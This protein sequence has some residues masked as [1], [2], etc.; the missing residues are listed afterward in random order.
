MAT[1]G[2]RILKKKKKP[3]ASADD[4]RAANGLAR[5]FGIAILVLL[6][7]TAV[8]MYGVY[9]S[10]AGIGSGTRVELD[11]QPK[12][13]SDL[14]ETLKDAGL[15][16]NAPVF[17]WYVRLTGGTSS[18]VRGHHILTNDVTPRELLHRLER[19]N[20]SHTKI[21]VPEGWNRFDIAKRLDGAHV[22]T[23]RTFLEATTDEK[24][25]AELHI[26][27]PSAE[28]YLFPATYDLELDSDPRDIVKQMVH[29]FDKRY[30]AIDEKHE[31]GL[32]DLSDSLGWGRREIGD[33]RVARRKGSRGGRRARG[34]RERL[35]E[36]A[37]G[38]VV[39]A[40]APAKRSII[41]LRVPRDDDERVHVV[42]GKSHARGQRRSRQPVQHV[43]A[44]RL[45]A[46]AHRQPRREITRSRDEPC[47]HA[48]FLLRREGRRSPR[49]LGDAR[50]PQRRRARRRGTLSFSPRRR[51][52]G[53]AASRRAGPANRT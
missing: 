21:V 7:A 30:A 52:P 34:R 16:D 43:H 27:G 24:L 47:A 19:R 32:K 39:H 14:A 2:K 40:E 6:A 8:V 51:S 1:R 36:P 23:T 53:S 50:Q 5:W 48:L 45:A 25:L 18:I 15:I 13:A 29:Q 17:A 46:R 33:P 26:Q 9:P 37:S 20:A 44:R 38:S 42:H 11:I 3:E 4:L 31:A 35:L 49:V 28:G 10:R 41:G 22:A 12:S